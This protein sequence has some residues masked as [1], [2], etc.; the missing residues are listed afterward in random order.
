MS[1]AVSPLT[2]AKVFATGG[3]DGRARIWSYQLNQWGWFLDYRSPEIY[4]DRASY[5][6]SAV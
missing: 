4:D 1:V 3:G 5:K 2:N 6:W